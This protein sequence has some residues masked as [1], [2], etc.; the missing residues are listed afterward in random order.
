LHSE[1]GS[2]RVVATEPD[3]ATNEKIVEHEIGASGDPASDW[4]ICG[5][6]AAEWRDTA[7]EN[8]PPELQAFVDGKAD[9]WTRAGF[10][11]TGFAA[12]QSLFARSNTPDG[13]LWDFTS[14]L[15]C[16]GSTVTRT[17]KRKTVDVGAAGEP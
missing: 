17:R 14:K 8:P 16:K 12:R 6:V 15:H 5:A 10:G 7:D 2:G 4:G 3:S 9:L 1:V 11:C 13:A